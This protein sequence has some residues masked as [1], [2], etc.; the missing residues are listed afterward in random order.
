MLGGRGRYFRNSTVI[1]YVEL[2]DCH[3]HSLS[4]EEQ[5]D[6]CVF[7]YHGY[8]SCDRP[9]RNRVGKLFVACL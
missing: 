1:G 3:E 9:E 4:I 6:A 5:K 7:L 8:L 2:V